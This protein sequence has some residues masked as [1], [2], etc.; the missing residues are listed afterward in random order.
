MRAQV[1]P[2]Y[3][4]AGLAWEREEIASLERV[5]ESAPFRGV[6]PLVRLALPM[7]DVYTDAHWAVAGTPPG[8]STPDEDVYLPG[9][10]I[11]LLS[12]AAVFGV[13]RGI[14]RLAIGPLAGNPFPDAT[15]AFF[16]AMAQALT[17]GL[18]H[19]VAI[20][21]PFLGM[22]KTDVILR[23]VELG[24]PFELTLSCMNPTGWRHCGRCSKCRERIDAFRTAGVVDP[25]VF[26][27]TDLTTRGC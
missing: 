8:Y 10:N 17:L 19:P 11:T 14:G 4:E 3:V 27:D 21:A 22:T 1:Q 23:G 25:A 15:P 7:R 6:G 18:G 12:K 20:D 2:I 16:T 9:R 5:L 13:A 24:V 26:D